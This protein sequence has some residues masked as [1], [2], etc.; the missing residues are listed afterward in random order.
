MLVLFLL[1]GVP[2]LVWE[3]MGDDPNMRYYISGAFVLTIYGWHQRRA[4][5]SFVHKH[6]DHPKSALMLEYVLLALPFA[7]GLCSG[8]A[9]FIG[10]IVLLATMALVYVPTPESS[11]TQLRWLRSMVPIE[12]FEMKA[13]LQ[14]TYPYALLLWILALAF[15]WLPVLPLFLTWILTMMFTA[16][17]EDCES[18]AMLLVTATDA[19]ALLRKKIMGALAITMVVIVPVLIGATIARPEWWWI[20]GLFGFGQLS[21]IA[22]AVT[23]KYKEYVPSERLT[24]N[25]ATIA[26]AAVFAIMP[27]LFLLAV[28]MVLTERRKAIENLELYFNAADH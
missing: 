14:R 23:L 13:V 16:N 28:L 4:D 2:R 25:G 6:I 26:V 10:F 3:L 18:R 20:H 21:V 8:G 24:A 11:G 22:L 15:C 5:L 7:V 27:G 1:A 19:R 9:W 12:L 17:L